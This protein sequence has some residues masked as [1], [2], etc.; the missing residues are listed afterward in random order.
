[1]HLFY[2]LPQFSKYSPKLL[3]G[4]SLH[5]F[6]EKGISEDVEKLFQLLSKKTA[7]VTLFRM[8]VFRAAHRWGGR[9]P[10]PKIC[11]TYPIIMK[12]GTLIC[13]LKKIQKMY[14]LHDPPIEF[15]RHHHFF[16]EICNFCYIKPILVQV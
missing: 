7:V 13:Y 16:P 9:S 14:K 6:V 8:G 2:Q 4:T 3:S 12:L 11:Q 5:T 10:L 1:M 15:C